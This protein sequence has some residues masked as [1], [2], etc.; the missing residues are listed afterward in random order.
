MQIVDPILDVLKEFF[1]RSL[2]LVDR[3]LHH[4]SLAG[5]FFSFYGRLGDRVSESAK[6][7]IHL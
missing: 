3:G 7:F 1:H 4:G 6:V 2:R 5:R